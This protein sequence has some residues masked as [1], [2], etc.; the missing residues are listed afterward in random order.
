MATHDV[1]GWMSAVSR[2]HAVWFPSATGV[3][4]FWF[5][6]RKQS[7]RGLFADFAADFERH[8]SVLADAAL[9]RPMS[10]AGALSQLGSWPPRALC[11]LRMRVAIF[12]DQMFRN[13]A[14]VRGVD[15]PEMLSLK[16]RCD[17]AAVLLVFSVLVEVGGPDAGVQLL[18]LG[19]PAELCFLSLVLRHSRQRE[20]IAMSARILRSVSSALS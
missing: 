6:A 17:N 18:T 14:A 10:V 11:R 20:L 13:I 15:S 9:L 19:T 16:R 8:L 1:E 4:R 2:F 12:L 7:M 3:Q 5:G